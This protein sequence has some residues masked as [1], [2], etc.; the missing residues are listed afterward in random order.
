MDWAE[1]KTAAQKPMSFFADAND[2]EMCFFHALACYFII[3]AGQRAVPHTGVNRNENFIFPFLS[4]LDGS[5]AANYV[6]QSIHDIAKTNEVEGLSPDSSGTGMRIGATN[7]LAL[8]ASVT[9][10][11]IIMRGG[12]ELRGICSVHEVSLYLFIEEYSY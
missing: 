5:G 10:S 8:I 12:W 6:T 9:L 11:M 3:G 7:Y 4:H 1:C 2:M